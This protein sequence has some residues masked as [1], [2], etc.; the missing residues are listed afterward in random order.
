MIRE[1]TSLRLAPFA[2]IA[3]VAAL[4]ALGLAGAWMVARDATPIGV[5]LWML[6]SIVVGALFTV[7]G[8]ALLQAAFIADRHPS[9][10]GEMWR[11]SRVLI[12]VFL[13]FSL[14]ISL[15]GFFYVRDLTTTVRQDRL[16]NQVSIAA[17]KA[18]LLERE[19]IRPSI[20]AQVLSASLLQLP[21]DRDR[22]STDDLRLAEVLFAEWMA[23]RS[24]RTGVTLASIDGRLLIHVGESGG[25]V[26]PVGPERARDR[27]VERRTPA[28]VRLDFIEP[29]GAGR[30]PAT[31]LIVVSLDPALSL[32]PEAL[33]WTSEDDTSAILL[34]R[35]GEKDAVILYSSMPE[36]PSDRGQ[37]EVPLSDSEVV[38][39][40]AVLQGNGVREGIDHRGVPV[41]SASRKVGGTDWHVIAQADSAEILAPLQYR[42]KMVT[43]L[44]A[45]AILVAALATAGLFYVDHASYA[46]LAARHER[47]RRALVVHYEQ[48]MAHARD[49]IFLLNDERRILDANQA[50]VAGYG[51]SLE[52]LRRMEAID[53][54]T[55]RLRDSMADD[56]AKMLASG[57]PYETVH[58]R[59]D[60]AEF[61]VEINASTF[62]VEGR[63]YI[64]GFVRD[65]THRKR[66]ENEVA[67]LSKVQ[68][69]LRTAAG[70]LLR[71][72]SQDELYQGMCQVLVDAGGYRLAS[73]ALAN[74]DAERSVRFVAAAGR[75]ADY[76]QASAVTWDAGARSRGPT[77]AAILTGEVQINQDVASNPAM[78]LWREES[79]KRGLLASIGL[80]L[81][82][83][84]RVI[85]ALTIHAAQAFAFDS[86][87]VAF[88]V[89]FA[90]DIS[91]GIDKL[92]KAPTGP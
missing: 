10:R 78:A 42:A 17:T 71:A 29:L 11:K 56:W 8:T 63:T 9:D 2:F 5:L 4:S 18:R 14:T 76:L 82:A 32:W 67:R 68:T 75:D 77:G 58:R 65:I 86:Q 13:I 79:L 26:A 36:R 33:N 30:R 34:V 51:Y 54:R 19:L 87:E 64:Q 22:P 46:V 12:I 49:F 7:Y 41:I 84:G 39:V 88:L 81:R 59:K 48:M 35:R 16:A 50:A 69:A 27:L 43:T 62:R 92:L 3:A 20:E 72:K 61:P 15:A 24:D 28:G 37:R 60:G 74:D 52:E 66:L 83:G 31:G 25:T 57:I 80:P 55:E 91:Y 45:M 47:E 90:A 38:A 21:L 40:Q 23:A 6:P 53:L 73:V 70:I 89:Q 1:L 44:T 85:G